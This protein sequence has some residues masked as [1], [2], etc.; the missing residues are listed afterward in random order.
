MPREA[1]LQVRMDTDLL[2][3]FKEYA[4]DQ[5]G[6]SEVVTRHILR[7]KSRQGRSPEKRGEDGSTPPT[8]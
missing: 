4:K 3:W 7:L 5:G 6:M 1:R 2:G 8:E